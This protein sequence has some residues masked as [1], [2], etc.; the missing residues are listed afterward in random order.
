M[1]GKFATPCFFVKT[2]TVLSVGFSQAKESLEPTQP[3]RSES[4]E[5]SSGC[6]ARD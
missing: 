3:E 4:S 5:I 2:G 6:F 1:S